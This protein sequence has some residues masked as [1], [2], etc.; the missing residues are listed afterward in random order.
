MAKYLPLFFPVMYVAS[1][2]SYPLVLLYFVLVTFD[3]THTYYMNVFAQ[4]FT[5]IN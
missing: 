5:R 2:G 4:F 1:Q 3:F